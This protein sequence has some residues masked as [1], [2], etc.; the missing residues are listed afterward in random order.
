MVV[1]TMI[2]VRRT[3]FKKGRKEGKSTRR[4][5]NQCRRNVQILLYTFSGLCCLVRISSLVTN[6]DR[7]TYSGKEQRYR[8]VLIA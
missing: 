1:G 5:A 3:G 7:R 4:M 6:V 2:K 8:A